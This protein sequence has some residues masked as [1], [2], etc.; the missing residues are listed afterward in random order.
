MP[1][2]LPTAVPTTVPGATRPVRLG[3]HG[4]PH[5]ATR[6]LAS[7]GHG[8]HE[9]ELV[10]YDVA[11]PFRPLRDRTLDI[12]IVKYGLREPDIAF[13]RPVAFDHRALIVGTN[14]PLADRDMV[15]V[16]EAAGYDCF[17]CPGDFPPYVWDKVVPPRTPSG[18]RMRRVH[19]MTTVEAMIDTLAAGR[20]VHLSFQS[21]DAILPPHIKAL[22]VR[23]LPPAPVHLAWLR[24]TDLSSQAAALVSDAERSAGR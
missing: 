23:D 19:R 3:I 4:S 7:A 13:S 10:P 24:D 14:H 15:S 5:L 9:V 12:M 17:G 6:V 16:E 2:P 11:E 20:A 1:D 18:T 21:L 22:P 8:P